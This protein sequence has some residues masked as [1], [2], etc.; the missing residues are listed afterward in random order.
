VSLPR[1]FSRVN[2]SIGP[3]LSARADVRTFLAD[4]SVS[5]QAPSDLEL[6]HLHVAGFLLLV[7][8]C[9]RLYPRIQIVASPRIADEARVLILKINPTCDV[10]TD[11]PIATADATLAWC[12]SHATPSADTI[13]VAPAG[14]EVLIDLPDSGTVH[15]TNMLASLAAAAIGAAAIFRRVFAEL[16]PQGRECV[17]PGR[18]NVLTH[19][20]VATALPDLPADIPL[21]RVH[22][23]GAGAVGQAAIYTLARVS[24]TGTITVVD[25]EVITL[26]NLQRYVLTLDTDETQSKCAIAQRALLGTRLEFVPVESQW[27]TDL[28]ETESVEV[29]CAAVDTEGVRIALQ[30]SL[31][32]R[33]YNAWTQPADIGWSRHEHF[34]VEPCAACLYWPTGPR[35]SYH[36]LV[37][38]ALRQH[39]LRVLAHLSLHVPVDKPLRTGQIPQ[40]AD[41]PTP[42]EAPTW[43][44]SSLLDDVAVALGI[45][46]PN[47][48]SWRGRSIQDLYREGI[49]GGALIRAQ[50]GEIPTEMAVPLAHQSVLAG[51]ML[52]TQLV[53]AA[54]PQ[55]LPYRP[56]GIEA[57]LDL[58]AP[59]P[60]IAVRPRQQTPGCICSDPDFIARYRS[61]WPWPRDQSFSPA[62][63]VEEAREGPR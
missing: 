15:T 18:F 38:R 51:I 46:A 9:A 16:L 53:V 49:C 22:L 48:A 13:V 24:A 4:K 61:K 43:L 11:A 58:L 27:S 63:R 17:E 19:A 57:R 41:I 62:A 2:D 47:L 12:C 14:W 26:S 35:P 59:I 1:F 23:V 6:H 31:P 33:V 45:D 5:L 36:E 50:A 56:A 10:T 8:L 3:F 52:A 40:L 60:Q 21:G 7:N 30:A 29:I 55:L 39:E 44:E 42:P 32:R 37:A 34:G 28:L 54:H 25:P 20:P